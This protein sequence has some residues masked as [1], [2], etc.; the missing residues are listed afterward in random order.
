MFRENNKK[1]RNTKYRT[2]CYSTNTI[3]KRIT[4]SIIY[5]QFRQKFANFFT[6]N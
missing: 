2:S 5:L 6:D 1:N 3:V 4:T